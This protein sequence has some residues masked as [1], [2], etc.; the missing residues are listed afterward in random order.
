MEQ[1]KAILKLKVLMVLVFWGAIFVFSTGKTLAQSNTEKNFE[2]TFFGKIHSFSA[3]N[4][5]RL[6][7]L[8]TSY[9]LMIRGGRGLRISF[10][11]TKTDQLVKMIIE[12][13][14]SS[15]KAGDGLRPGEGSWMDRGGRNGEPSRLEYYAQKDYAKRIFDYLQS[16]GAYYTFECY[17]TGKGYMQVTKAYAK[18]VRID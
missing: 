7:V 9:P 10:E 12:F 1:L 16:S 8:P 11:N 15:R 4:S 2:N 6:G 18:S 5:T 17:N 3:S 14:F 13:T